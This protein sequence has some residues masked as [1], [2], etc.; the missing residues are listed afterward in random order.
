MTA[1]VAGN[2]A[3]RGAAELSRGKRPQF[4]DLL[5]TPANMSR[6]ADQLA[7]MRGA[8][9]KVG[10]LVSMD[11]GDVLPPELADILARLRD[12]A[13]FMPPAQLKKVL[14]LNWPKG[15]LA[16]FE[17]FDVRPI[18]AASIGQV[19]RTQTRDGRDMA[20]K[21]QYP[22]VAQSI[23]SDVANVGALIR[24]SGLLPKGFELAP[25]LEEAR[26]QL[27]DET[28]YALEGRYLQE[29]GTL[30]ADDPRYIVPVL[31]ADW[32]TP[33]IL[34]MEFIKGAPIEA[35]TEAPAALRHAIGHNLI[36]LLLRELFEFGLMQTDPNFANYRYDPETGRIILLDFGATRRLGPEIIAQ[37]RRLMRAG[38][39]GDRAGLDAICLEIGFYRPDTDP[40]HRDQILHMMEIVFAPLRADAPY[41]LADP[42]MPALMQ[43]EGRKLAEAGF[44]PPPLPIDVLFLQRKFG[45]IFLLGAK[46]GAHV[47]VRALLER[48]V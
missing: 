47:D 20:I 31:H 46:L 13:H 29:F 3:L 14:A 4:R 44:I 10:Q 32:T 35:A 48:F 9:M 40:A 25:Y 21:V 2:M 34:A 28:D 33:S 41:D 22:G 1:G 26:K 19:H 5:M 45:G 27:H 15:W 18:A 39:D 17:T 6:V 11:T 23:D 12:D 30:L 24:M 7:K 8:A 42:T 43:Q 36:E 16:Q 38:L 37:Y